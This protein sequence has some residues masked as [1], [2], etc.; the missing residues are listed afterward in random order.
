MLKKV[1]NKNITVGAILSY[2][3]LAFGIVSHVFYTP[4]LL[5][6]VGDANYGIFSFVSSITSW[7]TVA[8]FALNDSFIRFATIDEKELNSTRRTVTIY[9]KLLIIFSVLILIV[10]I[11]FL[12]LM[13]NNII[14]LEKYSDLEKQYVYILFGISVFHILV[15]TIFTLYKLFN[16]YKG[17]FA[18]VHSVKLFNSVFSVLGAIVVLLLG[19]D[20][21]AVALV[22]LL[23][24]SISMLA[25]FLYSRIKLKIG[26]DK[27][28][29]L[30]N[31]SFIISIGTFSIY[32]LMGTLI[33]E[34]NLSIDKI[35]L[36]FFAGPT[37]VAIYQLAMSFQTYFSTA[38]T[39]VNSVFVPSI[40]KNV[41][42]DEHHKNLDLFN[43]VSF[44]QTAILTFLLG[45]FAACGKDFIVC[46]VGKEKTIVFY[47]AF[48]LLFL[49]YFPNC[50]YTTKAIQ[51]ANSKHRIPTL[52]HLITSILNAT[53]S[54]VLILVFPLEQ[55]YLA[56][57][58]G[59]AFSTLLS[60][61]IIIPLYNKK[62]LNISYSRVFEYIFTFVF[63]S[64]ICFIFTKRISELFL[65][66]YIH[67]WLL[68][69]CKGLI[70]S[71][72]FFAAGVFIYLF[73]KKLMSKNV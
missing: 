19:F 12:I 24:I 18:F 33:T 38:A 42:D 17:K 45:G 35:I 9:Q 50:T 23:S 49:E 15:T 73:R 36:G 64:L 4:F 56:C 67:G 13:M 29:L 41:V 28:K 69:L 51:R 34:I 40:N 60:K 20:I 53:I 7:F 21:I 47:I 72:F 44:F 65:Y 14:P 10:G 32:L 1:K 57:L 16:E 59:T 39:T 31:K 62:V 52:I 63:V 66:N 54:I 68:F 48:V 5:K 26:F 27:S 37:F 61:W 70:Y 46:W 6:M 8:V 22:Q 30:E 58:I 3:I 43:K 55:C 25:N 2:I 71:L 11:V